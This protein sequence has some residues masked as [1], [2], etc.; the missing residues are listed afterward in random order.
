MYRLYNKSGQL[1]YVGVSSNPDV[2]FQGHARKPWWPEVAK[3][4]I[5]W[6]EDRG[7][8]LREESAA[9]LRENPKF[10]IAGKSPVPRK[11]RGQAQLRKGLAGK[12]LKHQ[13]VTVGQ[14]IRDAVITDMTRFGHSSEEAWKFADQC[15]T[16]YKVASG[17]KFNALETQMPGAIGDVE[18]IP[19]SLV[20][21][22]R[23][24]LEHVWS[25]S[26]GGTPVNSKRDEASEEGSWVNTWPG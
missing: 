4:R 14:L 1:L 11:P 12:A 18:N 21:G 19:L 24:L 2:R 3:R 10:N 23:E 8:A 15:R 25:L 17:I 6:F 20:P 9:I 13:V 5:E 22:A 16:A 26:S 7:R